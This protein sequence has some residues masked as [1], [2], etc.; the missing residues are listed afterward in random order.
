MPNF[1]VDLSGMLDCSRM[2][3]RV[4]TILSLL[5]E[6]HAPAALRPSILLAVDWPTVA[7]EAPATGDDAHIAYIAA[8]LIG[9]N[10][11]RDILVSSLG[12]LASLAA[13]LATVA[14]S[15]TATGDKAMAAHA[16]ALWGAAAALVGMPNTAAATANP[17]GWDGFINGIASLT[18]VLP[19]CSRADEMLDIVMRWHGAENALGALANK[20]SNIIPGAK[21]TNL[22]DRATLIATALDRIHEYRNNGTAEAFGRGVKIRAALGIVPGA[23]ILGALAILR[24][25]LSATN[26]IDIMSAASMQAEN[27]N[28]ARQGRDR[29]LADIHALRDIL[30]VPEDGNLVDHASA[31]AERYMKVRDIFDK[32][33][34]TTKG[35]TTFTLT[36]IAEEMALQRARFKDEVHAARV[37]LANVQGLLDK[38]ERSR[39]ALRT[40]RDNLRAQVDRMI[41][42]MREDAPAPAKDNQA[43]EDVRPLRDEFTRSID[44]TGAWMCLMTGPLGNNGARWSLETIGNHNNSSPATSARTPR[45]GARRCAGG[46]LA[47]RPARV[48]RLLGGAVHRHRRTLAARTTRGGDAGLHPALG[49]EVLVDVGGDVRDAVVVRDVR[50]GADARTLAPTM[51]A[52]SRP[53]E[54]RPVE[55]V[56]GDL[57]VPARVLV[58]ALAQQ[59]AQARVHRGELLVHLRRLV[60]PALWRLALGLRPSSR[61]LRCS[62]VYS[63][64]SVGLQLACAPVDDRWRPPR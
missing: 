35:A 51:R 27:L 54:H 60:R 20:A 58:P 36:D 11:V 30:K 53:P 16:T 43:A 44:L 42:A 22:G 55:D 46:P 38:A 17:A 49:R 9:G 61:R 63:V 14:A 64:A 31:F 1:C 24:E 23:D 5:A 59:A 41:A 47:N 39:D 2:T 7:E 13:R 28:L 37:T 18:H 56:V 40:E 62:D 29:A 4:H 48:D 3:H 33:L 52:L 8:T 10:A 21:H 57:Q 34:G 45:R 15:L 50:A 32:A 19:F 25:T 12:A 26:G 6:D